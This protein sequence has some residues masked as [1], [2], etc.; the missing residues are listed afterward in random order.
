MLMPALTDQ[1][2]AVP[3]TAPPPPDPPQTPFNLAAILGAL[4]RR[5]F[6]AITL[7]MIV[8]SGAAYAAWTLIP[9]PYSTFSEIRVP[10]DL[11]HPP[12]GRGGF[13]PEF[14]TYK[15][16]RMQLV[17]SPNVLTAALR[18]EEVS[19]SS[20]IKDVVDRDEDPVAY[21]EQN[22]S[23]SNR[24]TEFFRI[25][26]SGDDP[27][28]VKT[29][30]DAVTNAYKVEV[31]DKERDT[32]ED[33]IRLLD[34]L[35]SSAQDELDTLRTGMSELAKGNSATNNLQFVEEQKHLLEERAAL[36][37]QLAE[38]K[39]EILNLNIL[40]DF[41]NQQSSQLQGTPID[42]AV[43]DAYVV[44]YEEF[45]NLQSRKNRLASL[46][47]WQ[48]KNLSEN[49][50]EIDK[51]ESQIAQIEQDLDVF[52]KKMEPEVR[53]KL[54]EGMKAE[55]TLS[56]S[57]IEARLA[58]LESKKN[59]LE[60]KIEG[61]QVQQQVS[62]VTNLQVEEQ[63]KKIARQEMFVYALQ[64]VIRRMVHEA[65]LRDKE[66]RI[67]T[68]RHAAIPRTPDTK[69]KYAGT[70]MAGLGGFALVLAGI[71]LLD[72]RARRISSLQQLT[73][74][75]GIR[76]VGTVPTM[77]RNAR[78]RSNGRWST[79]ARYWHGVLTE[80][81]DAART[82]LIREANLHSMNVFM[83]ASAVGGEGK[84]TVV[85]HLATSLA[86]AGKHVLLI[87]GDMRRPFIHRTFDVSLEPGL[88]EVL[89]GEIELDEAIQPCGIAR[90]PIL[91]AGLLSQDTLEVLAQGRMREFL[92]E[93]ADR[94][95]FILFDTSPILPITDSLLIA[96]HVDG[97]L[98]SIRRDV[99]RV[100]K[101]VAAC[102]R[103]TRLGVPVLGAM[104]IGLD[105]G[106]DGFW[107]PYRN[108]YNS[109]P[110]VSNGHSNGHSS[111]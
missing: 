36:H 62:G 69:K 23:V 2:L 24:G 57:Q 64:D 30:V 11:L 60:E 6:I 93:W 44:Q 43:I 50:P 37:Q 61:I 31:V 106:V 88:A 27:R 83:V 58:F 15:Q 8:G 71:V 25:S 39:F 91:A 97:V 75:V 45:Q 46:L 81:I 109:Y 42:E 7:G 90:L 99:S 12:G 70:A 9:A 28:E 111:V 100:S 19:Q 55:D 41:Q 73:D 105:D 87:D 101:V 103:L 48:K 65:K 26:L 59:A 40:L 47:R 21:L 80:S 10:V 1:R 53:R 79:R 54:I 20:L 95:D 72:I 78:I 94:F 85:S 63:A 56:K 84:T 34:D 22:L 96:Q 77:P 52:R 51:T 13:G 18:D 3:M 98:F 17:T 5:W 14:N 68:F 35:L 74:R 49:H 38:T 4:R 86:R 66:P 110:T 82:L 76:V 29:V 33:R 92:A 89:R 67:E 102:E 108:G 104:A 16:T 107:Y 32:H